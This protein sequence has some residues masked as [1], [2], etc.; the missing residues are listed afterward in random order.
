MPLF[1]RSYDHV[2]DVRVYG[3]VGDGVTNDSAAIQ[4]AINAASAAG[5]GTVRLND[6]TTYAIGTLLTM[7]SNVTLEGGNN[8]VLLALGTLP[9]TMLDSADLSDG[10]GVY[11]QSNVTFRNITFDGGSRTPSADF[12]LLRLHSIDGLTIEGCAFKSYNYGLV[13]IGGSRNVSINRTKF[14]DWGKTTVAA[15]G[16]SALW[17][18]GNPVGGDDTPTSRVR[19]TDLDFSDARWAAMYDFSYDCEFTNVNIDTVKEGG[20]FTALNTPD[21]ESHRH[22]YTNFNIKGIT[23]Q[24]ISSAGFE[25]FG[26]NTTISNCNISETD[27]AGININAD[28]DGITVANCHIWDTVRQ[29]AS[30]SDYT[31]FG[32]ITII[33]NVGHD[34]NKNITITGNTLGNT[35]V[36][37]SSL[38]AIAAINVAQTSQRG[39]NWN[40]SGNNL[41]NAF[42]TGAY[43]WVNTPFDFTEPTIKIKDNL[44]ATDL[45]DPQKAVTRPAYVASRR[46]PLVTTGGPAVVAAVAAVD[47]IYLAPFMITSPLTL[48]HLSIYVGTGGAGSSCKAAVW[49]NYDGVNQ[50]NG[51][52]LFVNNTGVATTASTSTVDL[53]VTDGTLLPYTIYWYGSKFTGT[54]PQVWVLESA[55]LAAASLVGIPG[56]LNTTSNWS[57]ADAYANNM[58]T[59]TTGSAFTATGSGVPLLF[60]RT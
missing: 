53:D 26:F 8:T 24:Y 33:Q 44:G 6:G 22:I 56:S 43:K 30:Y 42:T 34:P 55:T 41:V 60:A 4:A 45:L 37:P 2:I 7:P 52:P 13:A 36:T 11:A 54:L 12:F 35:G 29:Q 46:Y 59:F 23:R 31:N 58:P 25:V 32:Q 16:G 20:V 57:F 17:L 10:T 48:T 28:T 21:A 1:R 19:G 15:E 39:L 49:G 38:Y 3:A 50:P 27:A 40:I 5:G 18:S 47:V 14:S 51:A 9:H